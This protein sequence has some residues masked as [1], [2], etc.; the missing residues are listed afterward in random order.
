ME[1]MENKPHGKKCQGASR[2]LVLE[3]STW[4]TPR[5]KHCQKNGLEN[6]LIKILNPHVV[7]VS[8]GKRSTYELYNCIPDFLVVTIQAERS[9]VALVE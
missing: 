8:E 2:A 7:L 3:L 6:T 4:R 9:S 5:Q 1:D